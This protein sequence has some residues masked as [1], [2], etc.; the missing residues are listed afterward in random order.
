MNIMFY[1]QLIFTTIVFYAIKMLYLMNIIGNSILI[2]NN[3]CINIINTL[4][5]RLKTT[6]SQ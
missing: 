5:V 6:Q 1:S 2:I 4:F 3:M